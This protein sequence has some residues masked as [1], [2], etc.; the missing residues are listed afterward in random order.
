MKKILGIIALGLLLSVNVNANS[1][2][3]FNLSS[4]LSKNQYIYQRSVEFNY[5][6][7]HDE[8]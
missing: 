1:Q 8:E 4:N 2:F 6:E 7:Q 5:L 3:D